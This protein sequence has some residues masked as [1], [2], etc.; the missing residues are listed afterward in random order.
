MLSPRSLVK[1]SCVIGDLFLFHG[2]KINWLSCLVG[3]QHGDLAWSSCLRQVAPAEKNG[4]G[5]GCPP[6]SLAPTAQSREPQHGQENNTPRIWGEKDLFPC[7]F[8]CDGLALAF[9][10]SL[11]WSPGRRVCAPGILCGSSAWYVVVS[12]WLV[13]TGLV[14]G[15]DSVG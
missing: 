9:L 8:P 6:R 14:P 5:F 2:R 10:S 3:S 13:R 11:P 7:P 4:P 12:S 1:Y 15:S